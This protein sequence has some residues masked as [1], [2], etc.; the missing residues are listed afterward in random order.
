[1]QGSL[2]DTRALSRYPS[3]L[4]AAGDLLDAT[5]A[6]RAIVYQNGLSR[7]ESAVRWFGSEDARA[8]ALRRKGGRSSD[9]D[10]RRR[11]NNE[12]RAHCDSPLVGAAITVIT[13]VLDEDGIC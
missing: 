6:A 7:L 10:E 5:F 8:T 4:A 9:S 2:R 13:N 12:I 3:G 11:S 1:L